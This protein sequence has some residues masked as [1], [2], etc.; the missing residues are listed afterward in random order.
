MA[1][2]AADLFFPPVI[3]TKILLA[4]PKLVGAFTAAVMDYYTWKLGERVGLQ[5]DEAT[6]VLYLAAASP[7][8]WFVSTRTLSNC[9][10]TTLTVVG[11]YH[12]PWTWLASDSAADARYQ[13]RLR[14]RYSLLFAGFATVLRPSNIL[15]WIPLSLVTAARG[16]W[17]EL[18]YLIHFTLAMG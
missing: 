6:A 16:S 15:V 12:W 7:W 9:L 4:P 10:E 14:L 8:Q 3:R 17:S 2:V 5:G 11:L 13:D 1:D 18:G